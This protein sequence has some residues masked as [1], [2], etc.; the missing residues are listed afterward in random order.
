MRILVPLVMLAAVLAPPR[1]RDVPQLPAG[2]AVL[3]G[4]VVADEPNGQPIR[5]A[6]ITFVVDS[7]GRQLH[8]TSTDDRGRFTI[9]GLPAGNVQLSASKPGY[10]YE[11]MRYGVGAPIAVASGKTVDVTVRLG[12]GGVIAGTVRD[13]NGQAMPGVGVRVQRV[14]VSASGRRSFTSVGGATFPPTDDRG[15]YRIYGLPAG[16][17]IV[18]AQPRLAAGAEVRPTTAA[19]LQWAE[20]QLRVGA[21][22]AGGANEAAATPA[23]AQ[24]VTYAAVFFP[25]TVRSASAGIVSLAAGQERAGV[26]L[27]M[28]FVPTARVEGVVLNQA[29]QPAAGMTVSLLPKDDSAASLDASRQALLTELGLAAGTGA[30]TD[31]TGAFSF[32][33]VEPGAYIVLARNT[34]TGRGAAAGVVGGGATQ[35]AMTDVDVDGRDVTGLSL[36]LAPGQTVSGR[37]VFEGRGAIT[38]PARTTV[39]MAAVDARGFSAAV[40]VSLAAASDPFEIPGLVPASYRASAMVTGWTLQSVTVGGR[41]VTDVPLEIKPGEDLTG[42]VVTFT[43]SP[44]EVTGT[45]YDGANRPTSDLSIVLFSADRAMWFS[46]SRRVRPAARPASDGRFTFAG[47]AP[48]DYYLAALTEVSAADL[49]DP[50]FLE[51]VIPAAVKISIAAG[52]KKTQDLKVAR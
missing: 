33:G 12:R 29:G 5:R 19:E 49:A 30:R 43:D 23:P 17:Y 20:R 27:K 13:E 36:R 40:Q 11:P 4:T 21:A 10:V 32:P 45:L 24:T 48:G 37:F 28:Q 8:T 6:L 46:G 15:A 7:D 31:P 39:S 38:T 25:G 35:W 9:A 50:Q 44:A 1:A 34:P 16:D 41:D 26:D 52:E 2:T 47:L 51:L 22:G 42:V 14:T 18:S 3:T